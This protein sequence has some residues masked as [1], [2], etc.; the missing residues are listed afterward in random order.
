MRTENEFRNDGR[1]ITIN[2]PQNVGSGTTMSLTGFEFL[3]YE[4]HAPKGQNETSTQV[5]NRINGLPYLMWLMKEKI[6]TNIYSKTEIDNMLKSAGFEYIEGTIQTQGGTVIQGTSTSDDRFDKKKIIVKINRDLT[7]NI[8]QLALTYGNGTTYTS[9]LTLY[10]GN[11]LGKTIPANSLIYLIYNWD[12][13]SQSSGTWIGNVDSW[14]HIETKSDSNKYYMS[15]NK[16]AEGETDRIDGIYSSSNITVKPSTGE[17]ISNNLEIT[18]HSD[19]KTIVNKEYVDNIIS[20][21]SPD[22]INVNQKKLANNDSNEYPLLL[23]GAAA[24]TT[25]Y[26]N[27]GTSQGSNVVIGLKSNKDGDLIVPGDIESK[28]VAVTNNITINGSVTQNTD[29]ATKKYVDDS[30]TNVTTSLTNTLVTE[31]SNNI[32]QIRLTEGSN[33]NKGTTKFIGAGSVS[34]T[35]SNGTITINGD[36]Y[37][38]T[39]TNTNTSTEYN[40]LLKYTSG[41]TSKT[42]GVRSSESV[43]ATGD[44]TL[45]ANQLIVRNTFNIKWGEIS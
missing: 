17:I 40:I 39:Q 44:G 27:N 7:G 12:G 10:G 21:Y 9:N 24:N 8:A 15:F 6:E 37:K 30:I 45:T 38:V 2:D 35:Q 5:K 3:N 18:D 43:K 13:T 14:V 34:I 26:N 42:E 11:L 36:D 28:S 20:G 16:M 33:T 31:T 23:G 22:D 1:T 29:A 41:T 25:K 19:P 4:E 32:A